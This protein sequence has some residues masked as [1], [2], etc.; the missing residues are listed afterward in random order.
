MPRDN[1]PHL[2]TKDNCKLVVVCAC[3]QNPSVD[4]K[5]TS[6]EGRRIDDGIVY[7]SVLPR[8]FP[9]VRRRQGEEWVLKLARQS[10]RGA[11]GDH[12]ETPQDPVDAAV[13]IASRGYRR[14]P[15]F[16]QRVHLV[17][18]DEPTQVPL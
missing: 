1:V 10:R 12:E 6:G 17:V 15:R 18:E 3:F 9:H 5:P 8:E 16:F 2:V 13:M 14:V 11:I 4:E 7:H